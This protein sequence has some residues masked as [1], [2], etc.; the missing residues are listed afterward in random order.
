MEEMSMR[1]YSQTP[2]REPTAEVSEIPAEAENLNTII[3]HLQEAVDILGQ[4]L[5]LVLILPQPPLQGSLGQV[6]SQRVCDTELGRMIQQ[7]GFSLENIIRTIDD[8]RDRC[9]L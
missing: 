4:R 5:Q 2:M 7:A 3:G 1:T 8:L 6:E 9:Q